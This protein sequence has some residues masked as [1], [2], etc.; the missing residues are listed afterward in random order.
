MSN[1]ER[2][3]VELSV[4]E[5]EQLLYRKKRVERRQ[6]LQRLKE[7]GRVVEVAGKPPPR[8]LPPP[9]IRPSVSTAGALRRYDLDGLNGQHEAVVG[10]EFD[11]IQA[12]RRWPWRTIF[13]RLLL[14]VEVA[15][16]IGLIYVGLSFWETS[17]ELN[18]ELAQVRQAGV[19]EVALPTLTPT[20]VIGVAVLPSGHRPP[21]AGRPPEP[22][23]AGDIPAHLL[24]VINAYVPPPI[25][26]PGPEQARRI[27]IPAISVDAVIFQGDDWE[28]LKK[29][30][31]QHIPSGQPGRPGNMV[32]SAHND[33]FGEIFRHLDKLKPG[34]EFYVSTERQQ[35]TYVVRE[36]RV[37]EPTDVWVLQ[38]TDHAS[39]TLISCYPYLVNNKRIIVFADLATSS[40]QI[41]GY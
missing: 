31:G 16:V 18:R 34:D 7:N 23:E 8:P 30:V 38:P 21:V 14:L 22:G 33:I 41:G 10:D 17:Q 4:S 29:G 19:A 15:A 24:P 35:Y 11:I 32:L 36:L 39:A 6:R 28:Q 37:V 2:P 27:Q 9:L 12:R 20:P 5:L 13:N 40:G 26:T 25:P 1:E 3:I